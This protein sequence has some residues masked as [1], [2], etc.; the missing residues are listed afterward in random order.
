[1]YDYI[2]VGQGLAGSLFAC[3]CIQHN[4]A[5]LLIDPKENNA[6][7]VSS[8]M[9]NPVILKRFTSVWNA[10]GQIE[11]VEQAF[12]NIENILQVNL[13]ESIKIYRIFH[14]FEEQNTWLKKANRE[15]LASFLNTKIHSIKNPFIKNK[16]D[17]GEILRGG[18]VNVN[19]FLEAFRDHIKKNKQLIEDKLVYS[20][21]KIKDAFIEYKTYKAKRIVFC[22]GYGLKE[23]PFFNNLPLVGNKGE[24]MIIKCSDLDLS[25]V[26][27]SKVFIMPLEDDY[28]FVGA[29]YNWN[30]KDENPTEEGKNELTSKLNTFLKVDYDIVKHQAGLRPTVIDRRP[31]VGRHSIYHNLYVLNGLGT[32]GIMLGCSMADELYNFIE[33]KRSLTKEIDI[34][35]FKTEVK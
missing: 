11:E 16:F 18:K 35:R 17:S 23:N 10:L 9:Y 34:N 28:Y 3:K 26:V 7:K 19:L 24:T 2:I 4:K 30:D 15:D 21:L 13:I 8:G 27:K 25:S 12:Q 22:E 31:L 33:N 14:S 6:S 5:F 32:R 29:T 20:K 1:M